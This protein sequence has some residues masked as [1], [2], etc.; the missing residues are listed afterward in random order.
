M[1]GFSEDDRGERIRSLD[2]PETIGLAEDARPSFHTVVDCADAHNRRL[3]RC[4]TLVGASTSLPAL[5]S[6][7]LEQ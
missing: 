4:L 6:T 2:P 7:W 1:G 3:Q 5:V